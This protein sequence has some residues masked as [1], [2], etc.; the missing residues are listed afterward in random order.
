MDALDYLDA[1]AQEAM[2][3]KPVAPFVPL[4]ALQDRVVGDVAVRKGALI[5]C[6]MRRDSVDDR[7]F[8]NAGAFEPERWLREGHEAVD[9]QVSTPFGAGLRMCPGRYLALLEI[10]LAAAMLLAR[11]D[12][13]S[14]G[15]ASGA[16]PEE[17]MDFTMA[18]ETL[19]MR[20]RERASGPAP[21]QAG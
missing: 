6:V 14:V 11:F 19:Q 21:R 8:R 4:E 7:H 10:K 13:V 18:P 16:P 12:I 1:C 2:R 3:L 5:W 17:Q 20:L 9:K 15:T